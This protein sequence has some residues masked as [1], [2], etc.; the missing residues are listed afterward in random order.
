MR[1]DFWPFLVGFILGG[2]IMMT[3]TGAITIYYISGV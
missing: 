1:D 2:F 3:I